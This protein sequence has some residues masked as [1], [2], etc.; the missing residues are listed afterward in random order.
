ML[1]EAKHLAVRAAGG[2]PWG[3]I[4]RRRKQRLRMTTQNTYASAARIA[5]GTSIAAG[6]K[7]RR[8]A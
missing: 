8:V 1:S 7:A 3:E 4:L 5:A 2:H 6:A